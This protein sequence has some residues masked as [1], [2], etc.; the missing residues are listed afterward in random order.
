MSDMNVQQV[1]AQMRALEAQAKSQ[2]GPETLAV[3]EV[4]GANTTNF[5][6]VLA[7]HLKKVIQVFPWQS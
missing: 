4:Q 7:R 2:V 1:L 6:E 3:N 5:S